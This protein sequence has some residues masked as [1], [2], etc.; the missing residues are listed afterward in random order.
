MRAGVIA[1]LAERSDRCV[2]NRCLAL[3][4]SLFS[5]KRIECLTAVIFPGHRGAHDAVAHQQPRSALGL[6][7][8]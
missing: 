7:R 2:A 4:D 3:R 6:Y 1:L 5:L 8:Q